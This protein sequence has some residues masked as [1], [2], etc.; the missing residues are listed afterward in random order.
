MNPVNC[1]MCLKDPPADSLVFSI[2]DT[3]QGKPLV[4]LIDELF[5]IKVIVEDRLLNVCVECVNK[6]N[7]VQ[8]IHRLFVANNDKLQNILHDEEV[9]AIGIDN[10]TENVDYAVMHHSDEISPDAHETSAVDRELWKTEQ[11]T[12]RG[13]ANGGGEEAEEVLLTAR[14]R[15][16]Q[17]IEELFI[18]S[19][20]KCGI[21][22]ADLE[23][24]DESSTDDQSNQARR[25]AELNRKCY[26]CGALF[27][28]SLEYINHLTKHIDRVP[29]SC[30][31]CNGQVLHSLQLASKH[32]G[33]HDRT[34]RP[35][36]CRVCSL[37]FISKDRS[38]SHERKVHRYKL[39]QQLEKQKQQ[40]SSCRNQNSRSKLT[41]EALK[42]IRHKPKP[43]KC[44][45]CGNSFT[46]KRNLNRHMRLHTGEKPH[47]CHGC[48]RAFRQA[49][50]L[51]KH[52]RRR[53]ADATSEQSQSK[54][55][56]SE[57]PQNE[58][59]ADKAESI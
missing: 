45:L 55:I 39:R 43:F 18:D 46:L 19:D 1:R 28:T 12:P 17:D 7:S 14:D 9:E 3:V 40:L 33:M 31:E 54:N 27:S 59:A 36:G 4:E 56:N 50:D 10:E 5:S 6:I 30:N 41:L 57:P 21:A 13:H 38:L 44:G 11:G 58:R 53:H 29:Y 49:G 23:V 20:V 16:A 34:D 37:R 22:R 15:N 48:E 47:K 42:T 25:L 35:Y 51:V 2:F 24:D 8:K 52:L 26:F 32:I